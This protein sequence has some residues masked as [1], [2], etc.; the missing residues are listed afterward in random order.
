[1]SNSERNDRHPVF[2]GTRFVHASEAEL[3]RILDFYGIRWLYEPASF[4]IRWDEDGRTLEAFTPDFY[5]PDHKLYIELTTLKQRLTTRKNRKIRLFR[6][7]YPEIPLQIIYGT[8]YA[9]LLLKYSS[10][11]N[12]PSGDPRIEMEKN[13]GGQS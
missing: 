8:D 4:P 1:M 3:A 5:L 13:N 10:D 2:A 7:R 11:G 6:E 12:P 9:K